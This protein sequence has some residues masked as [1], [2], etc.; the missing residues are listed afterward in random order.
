MMSSGEK[1]CIPKENCEYLINNYDILGN[2]NKIIGT[3]LK[4]KFE[5]YGLIEIKHIIWTENDNLA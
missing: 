5:S 4:K 2:L 1:K 3:K